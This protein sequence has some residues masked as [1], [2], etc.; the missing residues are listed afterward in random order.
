MNGVA[1]G[2]MQAL[3]IDDSKAMRA[4]LKRLLTE[5]G[6]EQVHEA[7]HGADALATL[8]YLKDLTLILVDW[9]MPEMTGIE[10]VKEL[11]S[12]K[13]YE[14]VKLM[15][16]TTET[17]IGHVQSALDQGA[18]EYLMKPF[19]AEVLKEK[20]TVLGLIGDPGP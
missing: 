3:V 18:N 6:F 16:V 8:K 20:L 14:T 11:R 15:M 12:H 2:L 13:E 4:I 10:F 7:V 17:E 5:V 1:E 19:T 9:N